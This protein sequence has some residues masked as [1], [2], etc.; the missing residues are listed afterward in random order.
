MTVSTAQEF[1]VKV[2][3]EPM[4][5]RT[6]AVLHFQWAERDAIGFG[7]L[8][9][10]AAP[11]PKGGVAPE[12]RCFA[13]M[14][15]R[16]KRENHWEWFGPGAP[17]VLAER[18]CCRAVEMDARVTEREEVGERRE[19]RESRRQTSDRR[20]S[21]GRRP[22]RSEQMERQKDEA[23][24]AERILLELEK[25]VGRDNALTSTEISKRTGLKPGRIGR[26][27]REHRV[28]WPGK[29][30]TAGPLGYYFEG[31]DD[32]EAPAGTALPPQAAAMA[33]SLREARTNPVP[34]AT[35]EDKELVC[36]TMVRNDVVVR[37]EGPRCRVQ[38]TAC[39]LI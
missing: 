20:W 2:N 12:P 10:E 17:D 34:A 29:L 39:E 7:Q 6:K 24:Q 5:Y 30:R 11:A 22:E 25:A 9:W 32:E 1:W 28:R 16:R 23:A 31:G 14:C 21:E 8:G 27:I 4:A 18:M 15:W 26:L 37:L 35:E 13:K 19:R 38:E 36:V 33:E 3:R